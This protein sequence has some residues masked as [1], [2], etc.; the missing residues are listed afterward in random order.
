[1]LEYDKV[2]INQGIDINKNISISKRCWLCGYWY[3]IDENFNYQECM[4][5]GC[6]DMSLKAISLHNSC[7]GYNNRNAYRINF[8][9]M[10]KNDALNL[11]ENTVIIDK[12][13][14]L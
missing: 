4:C 8:A 1:M 6:L 9:F 11:I 3:F 14:T 7:I 5:N 13:G 12:K 2:D 10:S